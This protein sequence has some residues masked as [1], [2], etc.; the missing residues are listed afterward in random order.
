MAHDRRVFLKRLTF[1]GTGA[2]LLGAEACKKDEPAAAPAPA[3]KRPVGLKPT[4]LTT[5]HQTFTSEEYAQVQAAC[6]RLLPKDEDPGALDTNVPVYL[7]RMLQSPLLTQ[8]KED[9]LA[10]LAALDRRSNR[11]FK[12]GFAQATAAQQDELLTLFK[13]S[14]AGTGEGHFYEV[15]MVL[16]LEGFLGDPS[17]GG[18][19]DGAGWALIGYQAVGMSAAEPQPGYDGAKHLSHCKGG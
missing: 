8:M 9:F 12:V 7:D 1:V 16:T 3:L 15:L 17:Y 4:G 14:G 13:D 11:L 5:S 10:G 18:N 6:E 19:K 2:A